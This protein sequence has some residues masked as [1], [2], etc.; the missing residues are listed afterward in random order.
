MRTL[1]V[2]ALL[3][4][5]AATAQT[6]QAPT[7]GGLSATQV[8][9]EPMMRVPTATYVAEANAFD[10]WTVA[11][12]RLALTRSR[13][14]MVRAFARRSL[15]EHAAMQHARGGAARSDGALSASLRRLH[16]AS[17]TQ[18]DAAFARAQVAVHRW[19]WAL[20]SGYAADGENA[21]LRRAA[22]VAVTIEERHLRALPLR[23]MPY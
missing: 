1:L 10:T 2:P 6:V 13:S 4:A 11:A 9:M 22:A 15:A 14:P 19:G 20:H 3:L 23:P 7:M 21:K 12:S 5:G 18:F 16:R 8:G 17:A